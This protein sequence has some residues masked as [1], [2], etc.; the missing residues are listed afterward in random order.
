MSLAVASKDLGSTLPLVLAG[1]LL[2]LLLLHNLHLLL[3]VANHVAR[4][5]ST[6]IHEQL[7]EVGTTVIL[8]IF[9]DSGHSVHYT[10]AFILVSGRLSGLNIE[11]YL[12]AWFFIDILL[13]KL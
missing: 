10:L 6:L 12:V 7:P 3:F 5:P 9:I 13:L 2:L 11:L 8:L 1:L 4:V